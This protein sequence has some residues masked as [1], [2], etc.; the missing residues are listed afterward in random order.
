MIFPFWIFRFYFHLIVIRIYLDLFLRNTWKFYTDYYFFISCG[1]FRQWLSF[2]QNIWC[3]SCSHSRP[4][5]SELSYGRLAVRPYGSCGP[6]NQRTNFSNFRAV[7]CHI[8][9]YQIFRYS[10]LDFS[11]VFFKFSFHL[12]PHFFKSFKKTISPTKSPIT[13]ES[14]KPVERLETHIK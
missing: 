6:V 9:F 8:F 1:D 14:V 5:V 11:D 10:V 13:E 4:Y 3:F 12:S 2:C 7:F